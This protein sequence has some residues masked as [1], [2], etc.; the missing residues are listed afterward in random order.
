MM[1]IFKP[2]SYFFASAIM[3]Y[4]CQKQ[5]NNDPGAISFSKTS[6][7]I[8]DN[9]FKELPVPGIAQTVKNDAT[10][11]QIPPPAAAIP[12]L[13]DLN[14][15]DD[16]VLLGNQIPNPYSLLNMQAAYN[17]LYGNTYA[18]SPNYL[19]VKLKP[20]N[21]D[22]LEILENNSELEL[23][24]YP[25]D[26]SVTQDGDY[27]QNPAIGTEDIPWLYSTVPV[28]YAPPAGIQFQIITPIYI[29][30]T[31]LVLEGM[32]ESLAGGATY[33]VT[34]QNGNRVI[35]RTDATAASIIIPNNYVLCP[36]GYH[37]APDDPRI[38]V[39][40]NCPEG[41]YWN[42]TQ[43]ALINPPPP[44]PGSTGIYV[45]DI[46]NCTIASTNTP[47]RQARVVCKRWFKIWRGYTDNSGHFN[48]TK[49]F[50]NNVKVI[51]KTKNNNATISKIRGVRLWQALFP[52]KKRIGVFNGNSLSSVY[53]VFTK[54]ANANATTK[55]LPYWAAATTHNSVMEFKDYSTEFN[56]GQPK[57]D[58]RIF[59][60]NWGEARGT[61]STV[62]FNK[63]H[64]NNVPAV[65]TAFFLLRN[66]IA[67]NIVGGL[68][69]VGNTFKNRIDM[70]ISYL[71]ANTDY[72]CWLTSARLKATVYHELGHAQHYNQVGCDYWTAYRNAIINELT[73]FNQ[74]NFWPYGTGNDAATAPII[75]TGEM[76]GN[77]CEYIYSNRHYGNGG[78]AA[79]VF[80]APM[81]GFAYSN[82][83][84]AGLTPYLAALESHNPNST[85]DT[86]P[87]IP[88]GLPYD[89][90]D[91]RN[92]GGFPVIDNVINYSYQ[93]SFNA[94]QNDI[95][96]VPAFRNRLLQQNGNS[97]QIQVTQL[98]T[99]YGY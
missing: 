63:C 31:D 59:V 6:L 97:Q 86:W 4:G 87:W 42:G 76:W 99:Q 75:A 48:C 67:A 21:V 44:P 13:I 38:C 34:I 16:E 91:D 5:I 52:V 10:S 62:M 1:R 96:S 29:P 70:T 12:P 54:P 93:Q 58:L 45:E 98:F 40:D 66:S 37:N 26:Y 28:D 92:D 23:Q 89:L 20:A 85:N 65:W 77:H 56:L 61:G 24:D 7:K 30:D 25:M 51:V 72:N 36:P 95:K 19:Y 43:C 84:V 39:P 90:F 73:K 69:A 41:Y 78:T 53:Y 2:L 60:T 94:L 11:S 9:F 57:D 47:L 8:P 82:T 14:N 46:R 55:E 50:R 17:I 83:S 18:L 35:T 88:Q 15:G 49:N 68:I 74:T 3:L 33:T 27:Y 81:Q 71:P 64:N 80:T 79:S 22:E 32:A